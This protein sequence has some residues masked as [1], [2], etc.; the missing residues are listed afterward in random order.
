MNLKYL[1]PFPQTNILTY[2]E[3]TYVAFVTFFATS[4]VLLTND[5]LPTS[6]AS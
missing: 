3:Y 4:S 5:Q 2:P 1:R 6:V